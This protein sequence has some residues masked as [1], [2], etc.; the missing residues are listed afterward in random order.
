MAKGKPSRKRKQREQKWIEG[1]LDEEREPSE[2]QFFV[3]DMTTG[4][5]YPGL[6]INEAKAM[7]RHIGNA[8]YLSMDHYKKHTAPLRPVFDA[9]PLP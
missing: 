2:G 8:I 9:G 4:A 3:I 5:K 6:S 1:Q 7:W